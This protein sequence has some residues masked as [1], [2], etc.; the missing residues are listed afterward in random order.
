[1]NLLVVSTVSCVLGYVVPILIEYIT[2]RLYTATKHTMELRSE[3][4]NLKQEM[5]GI[6]IVDEFAKYAKL[7]RKYNKLE[8]TLKEKANERLSSRLKVQVFVTG[9][10]HVLNGLFMVVL[11]FLYRNKPVIVLPRGTLWPLQNLLSW[12]C[13]HEDSISLVVWFV[14]ARLVMSMCKKVNTT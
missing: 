2:S 4:F 12:P 3:L 9:G 10:F 8:G 1:M 11:L 13:Y 6:S 14:I 7:Q 5:I